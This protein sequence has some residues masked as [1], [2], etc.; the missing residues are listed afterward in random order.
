MSD[1]SVNVTELAATTVSVTQ[2]AGVTVDIGEQAVLDG[3]DIVAEINTELGG[4]GWQSPGGAG[5]TPYV[6][7]QSP[8]ATIWTI[9][10]DLGYFPNVIAFDDTGVEVRG[11][12]NHVDANQVQIAH[13]TAYAGTAYLS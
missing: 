3:A 4:T 11:T 2:P 5:S 8:A 10:H 9:Q 6:H 7:N 13:S 12:V 1:V